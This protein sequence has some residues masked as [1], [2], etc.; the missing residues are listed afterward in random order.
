MSTA[1][2]NS[3]GGQGCCSLRGFV[4]QS[5]CVGELVDN[6]SLMRGAQGWQWMGLPVAS[7]GAP[8][9]D[10][11]QV[12]SEGRCSDLGA[13]NRFYSSVFFWYSS[14]YVCSWPWTLLLF[15]V[16]NNSSDPFCLSRCPLS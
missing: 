3:S 4:P 9:R 12:T 13:F 8:G 6:V 14:C 10:K 11:L 5:W 1:D 16:R 15:H 2:T 7:K